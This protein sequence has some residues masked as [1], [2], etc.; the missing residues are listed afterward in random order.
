MNFDEYFGRIDK[1]YV[2]NLCD[3]KHKS[4]SN[5][6]NHVECKHFP[7]TYTYNCQL[8]DQTCNSLKA[9][10]NHNQKHKRESQI[11]L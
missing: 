7:N 11:Q 2:C 6:R 4:K 5:V 1:D 9:L 10:Q 3:F 8:C